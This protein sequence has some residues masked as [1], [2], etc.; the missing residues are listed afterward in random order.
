MAVSS[1]IILAWENI[2]TS[3]HRTSMDFSGGEDWRK[4]FAGLLTAVRCEKKEGLVR[5]KDQPHCFF[6]FTALVY[7]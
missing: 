2:H 3:G 7:T 4:M 1:D 5:M 6:F